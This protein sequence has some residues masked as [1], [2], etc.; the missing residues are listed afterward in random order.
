MK[1]A[2]SMMAEA[3][4]IKAKQNDIIKK[5]AEKMNEAFKRKYAEVVFVVGI[6]ALLVTTLWACKS[7]E[8]MK[9]FNYC[10]DVA[11]NFAIGYLGVVKNLAE[12]SASVS[13]GITFLYWIIYVLIWA[14]GFVI[15]GAIF[16]FL[17]KWIIEAY[18]KYCGE[19]IEIS[20]LLTLSSMAVCIFFAEY[21]PVNSIFL[22]LALNISYIVVRWYIYGYKEARR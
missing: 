9:D 4:K 10:V 13:D 7:V 2:K 14:I 6:Y 19:K 16:A 20:I 11:N 12:I 8:F 18:I 15:F 1:N 17:V 5:K 21:M 22:I 3:E